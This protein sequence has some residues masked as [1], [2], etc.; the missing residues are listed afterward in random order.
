[1]PLFF[2]TGGEGPHQ[3]PAEAPISPNAESQYSNQQV[4]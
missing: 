1:M 4:T 3:E 2:A